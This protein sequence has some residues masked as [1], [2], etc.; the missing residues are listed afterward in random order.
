MTK[1][2]GLS[3]YLDDETTLVLNRLRE[4]IRQRYE[5]EGI[6]GNAPTIGWLTRSLL[7]E[8]LGMVPAKNDAP[9]AL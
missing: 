9:G 8:K 6:P 5:R 2:K 1:P 3:V 7:R 4:E